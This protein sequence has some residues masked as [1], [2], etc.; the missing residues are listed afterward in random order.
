MRARADEQAEQLSSSGA[1]PWG[2][3]G[4]RRAASDDERAPER[5]GGG[6]MTRSATSP[7]ARRTRRRAFTH[8]ADYAGASRPVRRGRARPRS[9]AREA[10]LRI[11]LP[12][13]VDVPALEP[14]LGVGGAR[15][16]SAARRRRASRAR[17]LKIPSTRASRVLTDSCGDVERRHLVGILAAAARRAAGCAGRALCTPRPQGRGERTLLAA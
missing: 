3:A 6:R 17:G 15:T 5:A 4:A 11:I 13:Y 10:A 1:P 16:G 2:A 14:P 12:R 9:A 8:N 7:R